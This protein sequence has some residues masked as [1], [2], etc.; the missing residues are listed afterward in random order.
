VAN[1]LEAGCRRRFVHGVI[2]AAATLATG[3]AL[4][5]L[6]AGPGWFAL[7]FLLGAAA[8]LLLLQAR[9]ST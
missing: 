1:L 9:D 3:V 7:V 5:V 2:V 4:V 6:S 8:A